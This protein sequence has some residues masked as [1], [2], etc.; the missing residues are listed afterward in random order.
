MRLEDLAPGHP[1]GWSAYVAGVLWAAQQDRPRARRPGPARRRPGAAGQRAVVVGRAGVRRRDWPST[2]CSTSGSTRPTLAQLS[3][4]RRERLRRRPDRADG[5]ARLAAVHRGTRAVP[6]QP[7][8]GGRAGAA[9]PGR[10]RPRAARRRHPG[11]TTRNDDGG[12]GDRRA[13]CERAAR[14][15]GVPSLRD[16]ELDGLDAR[17]AGLDD[18]LRR[19]ARHVVTE[20]ARVVGAARRAA[21]PRLGPPRRADGRV[22]RVDARRL[23]DQLR[24]AR[25]RGRGV[26]RGRRGRVPG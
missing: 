17:L 19:R 3:R 10:R 14:E 16:V 7:V 23:R 18:E 6:R 22:A 24:R 11:A 4:Q 13:A 26:H 20:N 15:L 21:G 5:P 2:T 9:G 12:Y 8:A 25:R 1:D